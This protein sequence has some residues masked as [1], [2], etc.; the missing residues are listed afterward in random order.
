VNAPAINALPGLLDRIDELEAELAG[1][2]G[3]G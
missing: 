3:E 2:K 1:L